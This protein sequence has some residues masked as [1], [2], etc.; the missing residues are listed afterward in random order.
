[1]AIQPGIVS[2]PLHQF[3]DL[4]CLWNPNC[5]RILRRDYFNTTVTQHNFNNFFLSQPYHE[6]FNNYQYIAYANARTVKVCVQ[7][8]A[9]SCYN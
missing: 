9:G 8:S 5:L 7:F 1:M 2:A 6:P 3:L 4:P